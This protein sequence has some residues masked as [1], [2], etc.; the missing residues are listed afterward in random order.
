[1]VFLHPIGIY[2][3]VLL[4]CI[5]YNYWLFSLSFCISVLTVGALLP[6]LLLGEIVA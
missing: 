1:M 5:S 4:T 2:L 6:L 3:I